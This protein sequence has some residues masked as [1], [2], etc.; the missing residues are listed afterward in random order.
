M[1]QYVLNEDLTNITVTAVDNPVTDM[2]MIARNP[3]NHSDQWYVS[4]KYFND[5]LKLA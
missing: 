4:R 5:N 1:R 3:E 2:G